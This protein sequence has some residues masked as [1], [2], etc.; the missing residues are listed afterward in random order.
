MVWNPN[1]DSCVLGGR[2]DRDDRPTRPPAQ[3]RQ[4][5]PVS[6][7]I[8]APQIGHSGRCRAS[9]EAPGGRLNVQYS[10]NG[11]SNGIWIASGES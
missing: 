6:T 4:I 5:R 8:G 3:E 10:E 1:L 2:G 11:I 9:V 7:S